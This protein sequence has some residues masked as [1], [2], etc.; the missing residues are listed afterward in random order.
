MLLHHLLGSLPIWNLAG[1]GV[2]TYFSSGS[3]VFDAVIVTLSFLEIGIGGS[4]SSTSVFRTFRLLRILKL[5]KSIPSLRILLVTVTMS[6]KNIAYMAFLF[7][8]FVFMFAVLGMQ[9][10][11]SH[12]QWR[13]QEAGC[14]WRI[15]VDQVFVVA[16]AG[17]VIV[18]RS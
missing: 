8:L 12:C 13:L 9:R 16:R 11:W 2:R 5:A 15:R 10:K 6:M 17:G 14:S 7:F 4:A 3:N 18:V 1:Y